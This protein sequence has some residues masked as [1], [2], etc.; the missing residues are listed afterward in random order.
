MLPTAL[1]VAMATAVAIT[2]LRTQGDHARLAQI[3]LANVRA[4]LNY[5]GALEETA[6]ASGEVSA[7]IVVK[8]LKL[9]ARLAGELDT[10]ARFDSEAWSPGGG[11]R[12][13]VSSY[14]SAIDDMLRFMARG[15][16]ARAERVDVCDAFHAM[17]AERPYGMT[18]TA[19]EAVREL[20]RGAGTQF[21]PQVVDAFEAS[22]AAPSP[23]LLAA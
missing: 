18:M 9:K 14:E 23:D 13:L 5:E 16:L 7:E 21:D 4:E 6:R 3:A 10:L 1:A 2:A 15:D 17:T 20:R 12:K 8:R 22:L 11:S 19:E